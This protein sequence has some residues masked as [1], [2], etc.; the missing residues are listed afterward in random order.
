MR[1]R[2]F[3]IVW[4]GAFSI[5]SA[6]I[7]V[8]LA[9]VDYHAVLIGTSQTDRAFPDA[10]VEIARAIGGPYIKHP[11]RGV[12]RHEIIQELKM[13]RRAKPKIAFVELSHFLFRTDWATAPTTWVKGGWWPLRN[14]GHVA[15][16]NTRVVGLEALSQMGKERW[17]PTFQL[18]LPN[19]VSDKEIDRIFPLH[20]G[21]AR[22]LPAFIKA[23]QD[24]RA[25]G[26]EVILIITPFSNLA[27]HHAGDGVYDEVLALGQGVA[28]ST[29]AR[30]F[31][32]QG[33]WSDEYYTD[34]FHLNRAGRQRF[35]DDFLA[36]LVSIEGQAHDS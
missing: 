33:S 9:R 30:F 29:G 31:A 25:D 18:D 34:S 32:Y 19:R 3:L 23:V 36:W 1:L 27:Y 24:L 35:R 5:V 11:H 21:A 4:A 16:A 17:T 14:A 13:A 22:E 28:E 26:V 12:K 6:V 2:Q 20:P 10:D 15:L 7:W 8:T